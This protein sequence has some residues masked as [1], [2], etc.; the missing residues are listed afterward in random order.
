MCAY[1]E[2]GIKEYYLPKGYFSHGGGRKLPA[3]QAETENDY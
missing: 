1:L 3:D 2:P